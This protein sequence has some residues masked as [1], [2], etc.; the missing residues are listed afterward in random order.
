LSAGIGFFGCGPGSS[1]NDHVVTQDDGSLPTIVISSDAAFPILTFACDGSSG[2]DATDFSDGSPAVGGCVVGNPSVRFGA[3]VLP[4][5]QGCSGELCHAA[6]SRVTTVDITST[7]CC[8]KRKIV[9]PG[10]PDRSYL[11]QKIRGMDLCGNS[12]KMGDVPPG[13]ARNIADWICLGAPDN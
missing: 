1:S 10:N 4:V 12:S 13:V 5:L 6:W 11:L 7:E 8:D 3:D 9:D 2:Y